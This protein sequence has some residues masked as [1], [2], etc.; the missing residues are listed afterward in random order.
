[1]FGVVTAARVERVLEFAE[2]A[3]QRG[4]IPFVLF[5]RQVLLNK[6]DFMG[7]FGDAGGGTHYLIEQPALRCRLDVLPQVAYRSTPAHRN[8]AGIR[9]DIAGDDFEESR[10]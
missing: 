9:F 7:E 3:E 1:M 6:L 5:F 10:F 4:N 8:E 2:V